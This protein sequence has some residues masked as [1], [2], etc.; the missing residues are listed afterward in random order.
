LV[1]PAV[2]GLGPPSDNAVGKF[3]A[4]QDQNAVNI[5]LSAIL[6][7]KIPDVRLMRVCQRVY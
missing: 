3:D 1:C 5:A 7:A 6:A 2:N 4:R